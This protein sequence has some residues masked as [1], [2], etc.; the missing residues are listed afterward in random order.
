[1]EANRGNLDM[2][3][4]Q[5]ALPQPLLLVDIDVEDFEQR[6]MM[7]HENNANPDPAPWLDL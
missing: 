1:M 2:T 3:L 6:L 4:F 5:E 7:D